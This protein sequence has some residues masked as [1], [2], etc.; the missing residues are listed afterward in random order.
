MSYVCVFWG[1][2]EKRC[3]NNS[4]GCGKGEMPIRNSSEWATG[5]VSL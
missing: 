5:R 2:E 4:F 3:P 1:G